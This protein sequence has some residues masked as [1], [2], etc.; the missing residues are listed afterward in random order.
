[1]FLRGFLS[2]RTCARA[3]AVS[4]FSQQ[5]KAATW[6]RDRNYDTADDLLPPDFKLKCHFLRPSSA[7]STVQLMTQVL[8]FKQNAER[9][10]NNALP[11]LVSEVISFCAS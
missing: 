5:R 10:S 8:T 11:S 1:M 6:T 4:E 2:F 9:Q 3:K 7:V